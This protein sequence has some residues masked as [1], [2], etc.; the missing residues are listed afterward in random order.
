MANE[1]KH[2]DVGDD[3]SKADWLGTASHVADGQAAGD[4]IYCDGTY[5]K[6]LAKGTSGL[7]LKIG[8]AA[9]EW[10]NPFAALTEHGDVP[11]ASAAGVMAA[12][13]HGTLGQSLMSGGHGANPSW[14]N[15]GT[16]D[17]SAGNVLLLPAA[18][19]EEFISAAS[20]PQLFKAYTV[21]RSGI[22]TVKFDLKRESGTAG[23]FGQIY[24]N[25]AAVG[26]LQ[27]APSTSYT[28]Y[29]ENITVVAGDALQLYCYVGNI[30]T[31][32]GYV[33]NFL[34]YNSIAREVSVAITD[35]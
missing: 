12:L 24:V 2:A 3:L 35:A 6:R 34:L 30:S 22:L 23:V 21:Y 32:N 9:P 16:P 11:Y 28:T 26:T 10:A 4:I 20:S 7:Y 17:F 25:G 1:F 27:T 5:W 19:T 8:A 14:G 29:S 33:R 18:A 13:P 31:T 15:P